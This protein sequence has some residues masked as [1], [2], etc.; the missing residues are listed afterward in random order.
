M[1]YAMRLLQFSKMGLWFTWGDKDDRGDCSNV[2][3]ALRGVN[4]SY[5]K[6]EAFATVLK[7]GTVVP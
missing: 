1:T 4:Q 7:V 2:K 5:S 6:H 3:A